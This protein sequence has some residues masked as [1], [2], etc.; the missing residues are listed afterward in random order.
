MIMVA[1]YLEQGS[2]LTLTTLDLDDIPAGYTR[3]KYRKSQTPVLVGWPPKLGDWIEQLPLSIA[4]QE[5]IDR[6]AAIARQSQPV[7]QTQTP[8]P[9]QEP[10]DYP[11]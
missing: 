4:E 6:A 2:T 11:E 8:E 1:G 7:A 9:D 5:A 10:T 3:E